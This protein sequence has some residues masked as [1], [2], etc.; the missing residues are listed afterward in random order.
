MDS[1]QIGLLVAVSGLI[2][3]VY[4][5]FFSYCSRRIGDL[6]FFPFSV[7]EPGIGLPWLSIAVLAFGVLIYSG[8][9]SQEENKSGDAG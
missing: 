1:K 8:A 5:L 7:S 2:L 4:E 6:C 3:T 9:L